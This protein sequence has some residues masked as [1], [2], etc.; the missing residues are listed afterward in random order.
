M[1]G[2]D[3]SNDVQNIVDGL[4]KLI[5]NIINID[6]TKEQDNGENNESSNI[7]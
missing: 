1:E 2:L 6:Q 7:L 3:T 5:L 4:A